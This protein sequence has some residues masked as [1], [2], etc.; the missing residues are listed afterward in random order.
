[1]AKCPSWTGATVI[2]GAMSAAPPLAHLG[3]WYLWIPYIIPVVIVLAASIHAFRDQRREDR[4]QEAA[5][6]S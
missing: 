2:L 4:E 3:H 1:V 5:D 6:K